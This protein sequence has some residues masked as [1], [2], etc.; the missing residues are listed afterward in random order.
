[1]VLMRLYGFMAVWFYGFLVSQ[2]YQMSMSCY[3]IDVCP[4]SMI[5]KIL[6]N[7]CSSFVG[8]RL[9]ENVNILDFQNFEIYK[10][11]TLTNVPVMFL[12]L[13][14]YPGVSKDKSYWFW[15]SWTRPK[16]P[17]A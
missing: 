11:N 15:G 13:F 2:N 10:N 9:F 16:T 7:G 14:R 4:M 1:M 8:A 17:K 6:L 3:L 5:F 12:D